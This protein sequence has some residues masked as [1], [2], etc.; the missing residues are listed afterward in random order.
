MDEFLLGHE[1]PTFLS[2]HLQLAPSHLIDRC[3][4]RMVIENAIADAINFFHMDG[5]T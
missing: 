3:A 4:R 5:L 2:N 1:D